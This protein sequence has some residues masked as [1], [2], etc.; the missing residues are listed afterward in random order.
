MDITLD[1]VKK[2]FEENKDVQEVSDFIVSISVDKPVS[3]EVV[4]GYLETNEGKLLLQPRLD[5]YATKAITT[6]DEKKKKDNEAEIARR[7]NEKLME[8]NKED[9]PEQKMIKEQAMRMK[10]LEDKYENDKKLSK[11]NEIAYKEGIDP[12][13]VDGI[14]FESAEQFG[15]YANRF[16]D[17]IKKQNEKA[18]NDFTLANAH[19]PGSGKNEEK[20]IDLS[21][22]SQ[23]DLIRMEL[24]GK[25]DEAI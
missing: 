2:F 17:Y 9:T 15:L 14:H 13:F 21:K 5:S 24:E 10:E 12:A 23:A 16:K 18:L 19:K 8:L 7:V 4:A 25:L 3:S 22:L 1:D 20:K 6:H 11:I